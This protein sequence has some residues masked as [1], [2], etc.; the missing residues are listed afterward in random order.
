MKKVLLHICCGV[1]AIS[2]V[3]RLQDEGYE[4]EG[5]YFNPNIFPKEEYLK[6]Q[7]VLEKI[8][9]VCGIRIVEGN[10]NHEEW[11]NFCVPSVEYEK[12]PESGKRCLLCYEYR[13]KETFQKSCETGF[14]FFTTTLTISPHKNS[15]K[16][17]EIG[18]KVG[19]EKFLEIDFK[20]KDGFKNTI[21]MSKEYNFYRQNYCGCEYSLT[22]K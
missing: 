15:K 3:K 5:F 16:I 17:F 11:K 1:C 8:K 9:T 12:E 6:R 7:E 19:G 14:I 21:K 13:L 20:K 10:Y 22:N 2:S 4:V 18:K